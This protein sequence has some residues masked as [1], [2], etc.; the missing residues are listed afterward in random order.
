MTRN[1]NR[2]A[3]TA[4]LFLSIPLLLTLLAIWNWKPGTFIIAFLILVGGAHL[5]HQLFVRKVFVNR[6]FLIAT[7]L[8]IVAA[9]VLMWMNI[10]VGGILGDN[11]ANMMYFGVLLIGAAGASMCRLESRGMSHTMFAMAFA[12]MLVPAIAWMIDTPSA[13]NRIG[14]LFGL[15]SAFAIAFVSSALLFGNAARNTPTHH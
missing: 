12:I 7:A 10:A 8:A 6:S 3:T 13:S 15:H 9:L 11:P 4:A 1:L 14:S 5:A 2:I